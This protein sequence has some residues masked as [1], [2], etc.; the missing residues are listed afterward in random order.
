[1]VIKVSLPPSFSRFTLVSQKRVVCMME[2]LMGNM[3][4][5]S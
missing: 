5:L 2:L 3:R 1:M 4:S